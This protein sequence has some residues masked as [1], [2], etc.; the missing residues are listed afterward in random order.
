MLNDTHAVKR[1]SSRGFTLIASLLMMVLL[2]GLAI[3]LIYLT[4]GAGHVGGNDLE[5]NMAYYGA[6]SAMEKM[7]ADLGALYQANLA[8]TP[9]QIQAVATQFPTPAQLPN[10]VFND[11]ITWANFPGPPLSTSN[12]ISQGPNAGLSAIITDLTLQASATR[13][14][15]ANANM[16]RGVEVAQIPVFQFGIFSD[17]D[18]SFFAGPQFDFAGRVHTN[19]SLYLGSGAELVLNGKVTAYDQIIRDRLANNYPGAGYAGPVYIPSVTGGC[20]GYSGTGGPPAGCGTFSVADASYSGAIP[21]PPIAPGD[22]NLNS[23]WTNIS[24]STFNGFIGN[25]ASTG[26]QQLVLPFVQG[27]ASQNEIIRKVPGAAESPTSPLGASR[28]YNK[29]NIRILLADT[30]L[31]LHRERGAIGDGQ[32]VD[33]TNGGLCGLSYLVDASGGTTWLA[34]A[35]PAGVGDTNWVAPL[36]SGGP[37]KWPLV[38]G[39]LRV[40]YLNAA[41]TWV[42]VTTEWLKEGFARSFNPPTTPASDPIHP[43]AILIF[44]E[45]S[46]PNGTLSWGT[47]GYNVGIGANS[48]YS[49]YPINLYDPREGFPHDAKPA[50]FTASTCYAN[51]VMQATELNVGNLKRWLAGTIGSFWNFSRLHATKWILDLFL[52]PSWNVAESERSRS[53]CQH[54]ER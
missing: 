40:E 1:K 3:G 8:P 24:T 30:Q 36:G 5:S 10:M 54:A 25:N 2:S 48:E 14:S 23:N 4:N 16:N 44:Q 29:A 19:G 13:P 47:G 28:E 49:F 51:G 17:S 53:L 43:N 39:W 7:T 20:D 27:G 12:V 38:D 41:G 52:R 34:C 22:P 11:S 21:V 50:G 42:G 32:D 33:L 31:D 35:W 46:D 45:K 37:A 9:A 15:G 26:V 6:E 18:L